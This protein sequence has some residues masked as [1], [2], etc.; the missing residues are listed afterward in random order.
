[1][2]TAVII[3]AR[4]GGSRFSGKVLMPLA[5][6][7]MLHHIIDRALAAK[8]IDAVIVACQEQ[9]YRVMDC[10]RAHHCAAYTAYPGKADDLIG[11]YLH[12]SAGYDVIV[13]LTAD[14]PLVDIELITKLAELVRVLGL[15]YAFYD[16][17]HPGLCPEA[18]TRD[19]LLRLDRM[20]LSEYHREHVTS[21]IRENP[22]LFKT[23]LLRFTVDTPLD[24]AYMRKLYDALYHGEPIDTKTAKEWAMENDA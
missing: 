17:Y 23:N 5:G 8:G 13:R 15:D 12:A 14:N 7:P 18:F 9:D 3:Q 6:K 21:Y 4:S 19:V 1:M 22:A 2:K 10:V 20:N 24:Y 16:T 11:R